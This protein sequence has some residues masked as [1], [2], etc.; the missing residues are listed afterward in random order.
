[1]PSLARK[2]ERKQRPAIGMSGT[3][4][5]FQRGRGTT[6]I[7]TAYRGVK[8]GYLPETVRQLERA[9]VLERDDI[10]MIITERTLERRLS[11]K[12]RLKL[13]ESDGIA[14]LLRVL[15]HANRVFEDED[16]AEEWLRHPN[17]AL[18]EVP[19]RM[20]RT[21]I[22]AREVEAVLTRLEHGVFD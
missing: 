5:H 19:M 9:D 11:R 14:R 7:D 20:A 6:T 3:M 18:D 22:G 8:A 4:F 2:P 13:E 12:E 21:D 15:A 1:M 17:P 16:L 10:H